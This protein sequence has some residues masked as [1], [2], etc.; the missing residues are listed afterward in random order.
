MAAMNIKIR[1]VFDLVKTL[2]DA[3]Q[4]EAF[5]QDME[6]RSAFVTVD[7]DTIDAVKS[8]FAFNGL[9]QNTAFGKTIGI[10]INAVSQEVDP[11]CED[12]HC[13]HSVDV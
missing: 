8:F 4:A 1:S 11:G 3:D 6:A 5:I 9:H 10:T 7:M 12:G 13:E 2:Q